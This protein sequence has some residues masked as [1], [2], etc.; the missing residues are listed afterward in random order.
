M[1]AGFCGFVGH[2]CT[3]EWSELSLRMSPFFIR[4]IC[5]AVACTID[6]LS[7]H[8]SK[9]NSNFSTASMEFKTRSDACL[10]AGGSLL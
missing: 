2:C 8:V 10:D 4:S 3:F 5:A 6:K 7:S 9:Q 1:L